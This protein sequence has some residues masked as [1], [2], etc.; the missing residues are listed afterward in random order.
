MTFDENKVYTALNADE[1]KVGSEVYL[2]DS[3]AGLEDAIRER[4]VDILKK[5]E[6]TSWSARFY[7]GK[8]HWH[9]AYL[10]SEPGKLHWYDLKVG[11]IIKRPFE[12]GTR[13]AMITMIDT[14]TD[15]TKHIGLSTTW[16]DDTEIEDW[17]IVK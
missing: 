1:L 5:I 8:A 15:T 16:L 11:D 4:D 14:C 13:F 9:L 17:E 6:S 3:P 2:A 12:D 10:V 7:N